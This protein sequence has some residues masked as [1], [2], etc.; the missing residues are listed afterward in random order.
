MFSRMCFDRYDQSFYNT[1]MLTS[2]S[3][4]SVLASSEAFRTFYE[5]QFWHRFA[6]T[7]GQSDVAKNLTTA[8][9]FLQLSTWYLP[10]SSDAADLSIQS[11]FVTER[12]S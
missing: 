5:T 8:T 7:V 10:L 12:R 1:V 4:T 6:G 2:A 11:P 3:K 9:P